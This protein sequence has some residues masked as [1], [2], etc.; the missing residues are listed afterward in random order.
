MTGST[1]RIKSLK[2]TTK[3]NWRMLSALPPL[4]LQ[5]PEHLH[6]ETAET[7]TRKR[8]KGM[9]LLWMMRKTAKVDSLSTTKMTEDKAVGIVVI[10]KPRDSTSLTGEAHRWRLCNIDK[11]VTSSLNTLIHILYDKKYA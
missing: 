3:A 9:T 11:T 8:V 7:H 2:I 1:P 5:K 6:L 4:H 10:E